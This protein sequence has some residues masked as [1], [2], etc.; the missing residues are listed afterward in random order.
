MLPIFFFHTLN[1]RVFYLNSC[2]YF[3]Y[4]KKLTTPWMFLKKK[5]KK[6]KK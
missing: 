2:I 3:I 5:K 4:L 1:K 6:K